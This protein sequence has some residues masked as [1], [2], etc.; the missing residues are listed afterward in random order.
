M[1]PPLEPVLSDPALRV[2]VQAY[3]ADFPARCDGLLRQLKKDRFVVP[4]VGVQGAGKSTLLNALLFD[5]PVLPVDADE[6]TCVPVEIVYGMSRRATVHYADGRTETVEATELSLARFVHQASNP[7]NERGVSRVV[8]ESR[9]PI[10]ATGAVLVDLPGLGSLTRAN[11]DTTHAYLAESSGLVYL[12]RTVPPMTRSEA[13]T[14]SLIWPR[15]PIVFFAQNRWTDESDA[16]AETG[17]EHNLFVLSSLAQKLGRSFEKEERRIDL[18]NAYE[19]LAGVLTGDGPRKAASGLHDQVERL[20]RAFQ[21]WPELS[22]VRL[23]DAVRRDLAECLA[24]IGRRREDLGKERDVARAELEAELARYRDALG[25]VEGRIRSVRGLLDTFDSNQRT[26]LERWRSDSRAELRN[27]MRSLMRKGIVDGLR[28]DKALTDEQTVVG[29]QAYAA[30]RDAVLETVG[31]IGKDISSEDAWQAIRP[32]G[33]GAGKEEAKHWEALLEPV[34]G[35]AGGLAGLAA[36][37]AV[38]LKAGAFVGTLIAGPLGTAVGAGVG[39]LIGA[40]GS[41]LGGMLGSWAGSKGRDGVLASRAK[42]NEPEVFRA[43]DLYT[44]A[45][46]RELSTAID[47]FR[48]GVGRNLDAWHSSQKRRVEEEH[49]ARREAVDGSSADRARTLEC[50]QRDGAC[51]E[52]A[53]ARLGSQEAS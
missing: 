19:A 22:R 34:G 7:G 44:D 42:A 32:T 29:E 10:L 41:V 25:V 27:R 51:V 26:A 2:C 31:Q 17:R 8:V 40:A 5:E 33:E 38:G 4:V 37:G 47:A 23:T 13:V 53:I 46:Y 50:L 35:M 1:T 52:A 15:L 49:A 39:F 48:Q 12:L 3:D 9:S 14:L 6:T 21:S 28:L 20:G 43:I 24:R 18:V 16:E 45:V 11:A 36:G 30:A